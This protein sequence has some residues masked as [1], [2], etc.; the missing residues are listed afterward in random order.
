MELIEEQ[1]GKEWYSVLKP[2]LENDVMINLFRFLELHNDVLCPRREDIF[3]AYRYVQPSQL[4]VLILGEA[5]SKVLGEPDG[6]AYSSR[7]NSLSLTLKYIFDELEQSGLGK[8]VNTDLTDWA[9]QGVMLLN[10]ILTYDQSNKHPHY[11]IGWE[12]FIAKTLRYINLLPQRFVVM[13]WGSFVQGAVLKYIKKTK[14]HIVLYACAPIMED[15]TGGSVKF[16]GCNHFVLA[17]KHL[18]EK[19]IIW[20]P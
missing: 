5:P 15:L 8:R 13:A 17:N 16:V 6:F 12:F 20:V 2:A 11:N 19:S 18:Q 1:L 10:T 9:E 3:R 14:D 4:R 7:G